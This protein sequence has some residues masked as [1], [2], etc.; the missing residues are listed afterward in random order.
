M[1]NPKEPKKELHF[2]IAAVAARTGLSM[3][4]IRVWEKR[5]GCL[6][7]KRTKT[8]RRVYDAEDITRLMLLK[9]LTALGHAIS[10]IA[11]LNIPA[12]TNRLQSAESLIPAL[13]HPGAGSNRTI[14]IIGPRFQQGL[15]ENA[16][17]QSSIIGA[18]SDLPA[19]TASKQLPKADLLVVDSKTFDINT[20]EELRKVIRTSWAKRTILVHH[21][22]TSAEVLPLVSELKHLTLLKA[23][24][25]NTHLRRECVVLLNQLNPIPVPVPP[26][27]NRPIPDRLY[28]DAQLLKVAQF[29]SAV[30]CECPHHIADLLKLLTGFEKYS[31][32]CA[33][34]NP[35]DAQLH[36]FLHR[37][38][39]HVRR[40]MEEALR[41]LVSVEGMVF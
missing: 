16:I 32:D 21:F 15:G 7:A 37:T 29:A 4:L 13:P 28:Q 1:T 12:L 30:G 38:T 36:H 9:K 3:Q 27:G 40:L 26:G 33:D 2:G 35:R 17:H 23:P 5:Y 19:A 24:V 20:V 14:L 22:K 6:K 39:S 11:K 25:T 31:A 8:N 41:Y 10:G 34:K 18:Y